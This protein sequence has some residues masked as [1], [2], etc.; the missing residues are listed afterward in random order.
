MVACVDQFV[1]VTETSDV[2]DVVYRCWQCSSAS[3]STWPRSTASATSAAPRPRATSRSRRSPR[4][5]AAWSASSGIPL[6]RRGRQFEGLT[7]EGERVLGWAQRALADLDSL[8]Q[9][10]SLLRG[11]LEGTLRIG[12]IPTSL[13]LSPPITMRFRERH[14]RM[15][16]RWVSMSSRQIAHGLAHGEIDAGLTYLDNE[17]LAHVDMLPLWR[18]RYLLVTAAGS[19]HGEAAQVGWARRRD[20]AA[21]PADARHAAPPDRR[22]R[23]R[24]GPARRRSRRSRRTRSRRSSRTPAPGSPGS[25]RTRGWRRTRCRPTCAPSRSP[26][27]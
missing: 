20:A 16:V 11:G 13:P 6:V 25:P 4:A 1:Q 10:V 2:I 9:E 8:H 14:P 23:V 17:P 19:A 3:S 21:V 5:S 7:P 27:R 18:E 15:R 12:A 24:R 22:R 26:T